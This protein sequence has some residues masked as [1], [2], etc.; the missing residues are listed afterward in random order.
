VTSAE[1]RELGLSLG[2]AD[3][4]IQP[5]QPQRLI[6]AVQRWLEQP[7][8]G[9]VLIVDD[10]AAARDIMQRTLTQAGYR[11]S[12]VDGGANALS[13]LERNACDLVVL[14][15]MMPEMDGFELVERLRRTEA[16]RHVPVVVVTAKTLSAEEQRLLSQSVER[17]IQKSAQSRAELLGLLEAQVGSLARRNGRVSAPSPHAG[18]ETDRQSPALT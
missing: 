12:A 17:V 2:A 9:R 11:A 15:L 13:W 10:D 1:Q 18:A 5:V 16:H 3:H 14:D 8:D 4:L 7:G 6:G